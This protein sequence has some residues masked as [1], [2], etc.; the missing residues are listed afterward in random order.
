V[1][2]SSI[3]FVC[4]L[5]VAV[6]ATPAAAQDS[7]P[8]TGL[9]A[10]TDQIAQAACAQLPIVISG[11]V[12]DDRKLACL[13][14]HL[15]IDLLGR[16]DILLH[17]PLRLEIAEQIVHPLGRPVLA[18]FDV[19]KERI[20]VRSSQRVAGLVSNTPFAAVS[21]REFYVSIVVH[22]V[23][24]GVLQQSSEGRL[25]S[26]IANEYLAY[27]LQIESLPAN[28]RRAF[29]LSF[30]NGPSTADLLFSDVMLSLDPYLFAARAYEH[31]SAFAD[32]CG[33][34]KSLLD[35][36]PSFIAVTY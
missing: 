22:E 21:P 34:V 12:E 25:L 36:D 17:R 5:A 2:R 19:V 9:F 27:A 14:A 15:A 29:L 24:H 10:P 13:G 35:G 32:R 30:P 20:L 33:L 4:L 31:F 23:V 11:P 6:S 26:H 18:L 3:P 1:L 7:A 16:C 8:P 28:A